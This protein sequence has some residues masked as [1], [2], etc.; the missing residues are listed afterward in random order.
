MRKVQLAGCRNIAKANA[1]GPTGRVLQYCD[2]Q[3]AGYR[4]PGVGLFHYWHR[5]AYSEFN[6]GLQPRS[7]GGEN[8]LFAED[9]EVYL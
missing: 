7:I 6:F 4:S 9:K 1:Q 2:G 5:L 3:F 8:P